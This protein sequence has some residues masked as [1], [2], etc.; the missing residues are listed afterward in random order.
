[1]KDELAKVYP[2]T[3]FQKFV[4]HKIRNIIN[5]TKPKEKLEVANE[6]K[7][8][9]DNFES[10]LSLEQAKVKMDKFLD[11]WKDIYPSFKNQMKEGNIEYYFTYF[12]ISL[13][14]TSEQALDTKL[15]SC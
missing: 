10:V 11:K 4:V 7:D 13:Y 8:F 12:K 3:K 6:L 14:Q 9:F 1:M 15:T 2:N 5:K